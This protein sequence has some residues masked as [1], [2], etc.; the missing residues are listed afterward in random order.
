[1]LFIEPLNRYWFQPLNE[2]DF[3]S[4]TQSLAVFPTF[5]TANFHPSTARIHPPPSRVSTFLSKETSVLDGLRRSGTATDLTNLEA[6]LTDLTDERP[7]YSSRSLP[8]TDPWPPD[9]EDSA[10]HIGYGLYY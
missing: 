9:W 8:G 3:V 1:M 4:Y 6:V 5:S 7:D 2:Q 10:A